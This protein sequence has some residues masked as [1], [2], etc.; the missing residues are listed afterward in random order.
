M[1]SPTRADTVRPPVRPE[2]PAPRRGLHGAVAVSLAAYAASRLVLLVAYV[3]WQRNGGGDLAQVWDG[4]WFLKIADHGY[5]DGLRF[6]GDSTSAWAFLPLYPMLVAALHAVGIPLGAAA[7]GL[8]VVLGAGVAVLLARLAEEVVGE[9]AASRAVVLFWFFPGSAALSLAYSEALFLL[10]VCGALLGLVRRQWVLAGALTALAGATRAA[11]LALMLA[12]AVAAVLTVVRGGP[13]RALLA[14][15]LAPLGLLAFLAYG[16]LRTGDRLIW[17]R[18]QDDWDQSTDFGLRLAGSIRQELFRGGEN[19]DTWVLTI[20]SGL[21]LL[22]GV[23]LLAARRPQLPPALWAYTG[24]TLVIL[25]S[26]TN[27]M[28]KPR[29]VLTLVPLFLAVADR[30]PARAHPVVVGTLAALLPLTAYLW[31]AAPHVI[32]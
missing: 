6:A 8:N 20:V 10:L 28:T 21:L 2:R 31:L 25:L 29:F 16:G 3:L 24:A 23:A 17:R 30:L 18:A 5:P 7:V 4:G 26:S 12:C 1:T 32:P 11:A 22:A 9:P 27:V 15:L 14:P 13:R 19:G